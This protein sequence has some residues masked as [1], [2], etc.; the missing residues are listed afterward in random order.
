MVIVFVSIT[1]RASSPVRNNWGAV[2]KRSDWLWR[3]LAGNR[4]PRGR[5]VVA[6]QGFRSRAKEGVGDIAPY[7]STFWQFYRPPLANGHQNV[8]RYWK[9]PTTRLYLPRVRG[10]PQSYTNSLRG[11]CVLKISPELFRIISEHLRA[12]LIKSNEKSVGMEEFWLDKRIA[13]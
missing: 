1:D 2:V 9:H 12:K 11:R 6:K 10:T 4:D 8:I 3:H 7:N 5:S 13:S